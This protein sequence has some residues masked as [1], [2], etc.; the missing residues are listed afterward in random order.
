MHTL[1]NQA[2]GALLLTGL[3]LLSSCESADDATI[4]P[5]IIFISI[6][7]LRPDHLGCYGY[8]KDTSPY[9]DSLA[10]RGV[11]FRN[12]LSTTSWTLP[13]H[14]SMLTGLLG[15]THGLVD[16]GMSLSPDNL[17]LAEL[18]GRAGYET[19]GFYGGPYLHPTFGLGQGFDIYRS[20]MTTTP[21]AADDDLIRGG[22][23]H[24]DGPSHHDITG[25]RTRDEIRGWAEARTQESPYFL[26]IH[27][28]DVHYDYSA[29]KEYEAM[30]VD[31]NYEGEA[32]GRLMTN[33][34][35]NNKMSPADLAHVKALYDAEIRFTDSIIEEI[36]SDLQ[37]RGMLENTAI[38][39][40]ADH[41]EEFFDHG[42][43]GHNKSLFDEVLRVPLIVVWP[44]EIK[45]ARV[46]EDQVQIV[47]LMPTMASFA[48]ISKKL[49]VQGSDLSP[50]LAGESM[51]AREALS[52]LFID[53][54]SLRA[55]RSNKRKVIRPDDEAQAVY[56]D[57]TKNPTEAFEGFITPN[58]G[59]SQSLRQQGEAE[60]RSAVQ[61]TN[62]M[63]EALNMR[64]P[65]ALEVSPEMLQQL[66]DLGYIG[67]HK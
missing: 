57:L 43:K 66:K 44:E 40:T 20:C 19:A 28:W 46:L 17:T 41:G 25:P 38:V 53:G 59:H 9:I 2:S 60:L 11:R 16:N 14:A 65:G 36:L 49:A 13:S 7:S 29:P 62:K 67:E 8:E 6:D 22:A 39:L 42:A 50:L 30:F 27:F 64:P 15:P 33:D 24:P 31:P 35:I 12:A 23:S 4:A 18:L 51:G 3:A 26:F 52:G 56:V 10:S 5:N 61:R 48:G 54:Q 63:R 45:S 55:L 37:E 34:A 47:D 1:K 32:D 58:T 21:D